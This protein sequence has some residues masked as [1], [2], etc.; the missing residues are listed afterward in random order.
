[1]NK[2]KLLVSLGAI[3]AISLTT[4]CFKLDS[5][6][7]NSKKLNVYQRDAFTGEQDFVLDDSYKID[8]A[9]IH[10][11]KFTYNS[12]STGES[13]TIY[14]VYLG[15]ERRIA[16]D[17]VIVY[18]HGNK[19]NMDFY[20]QRAKLLANV[21]VKNRYGVLMMDYRGYGRSEG[22]GTEEGLYE[23]VDQCIQWL[24][25][26]GLT[27]DRFVIYGFSMGTAPATQLT[28]Q[29][30]SLRP[31]K[32]I[33]EAPFASAETMV[34]D[35]SKLAMPGSF[36][37]NLKIDN[38]EEIKAV[39]QPFLWMHGIDDDYLS[40][41]T[42]GEV[43]YKNYGGVRG[44]AVRVPGAGHSTVPTVMGFQ[45]YRDTLLNFITK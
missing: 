6:L 29:P 11:L 20:W 24:K 14:A 10:E 33:L 9:M 37:T 39:K 3:A 15:D 21:G 41:K 1:M 23:D 19:W 7:F 45:A 30:R 13:N 25:S 27:E 2:H 28:A 43:V 18:C 44:V 31:S 22:S 36:F 8:D 12:P 32:L 42:H 5:N 38:A 34:Q 26:N 40:I 17:T 4:A 35:A 16:T